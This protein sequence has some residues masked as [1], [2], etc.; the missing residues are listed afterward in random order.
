MNKPI[1]FK[2]EVPILIDAFLEDD[3]FAIDSELPK[4]MQ[5]LAQ[6]RAG[7]S[8]HKHGSF[9]D[10]LYGTYRALKLWNQEQDVC[11]CG[12]FHSVYSNEYVDLALFDPAQ[13]RS[14]LSQFLTPE[15]EQM[16]HKF[17]VMPRND[18]VVRM[19]SGEPV[20]PE[21][22]TLKDKAGS[23]VHLSSKEI[24]QY[25]VVTIADLLEQWYSWQEDTMA[26]YPFAGEVGAVP[27]WSSTLWP[28]PF[29]PGSSALSIASKLAKHLPS[30]GEPVPPIFENCT[31]VLNQ[32]DEASACA[33]FWSVSSLS[34]PQVATDTTIALLEQCIALNPH[35]GEPHLH[36]AQLFYMEGSFE[37]GV[38]HAQQG[39]R[40]I[41]A[42]G[43]PW[44]K[45]VSWSGWVIWARLL[46]QKGLERTWPSVLRD[47]NNLGLVKA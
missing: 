33:L 10:H 14:I 24:F 19:L 4:I 32:T 21:G 46:C 18:F 15:I 31:M 28:G 22:L 30:L 25:L 43:L 45:R 40:L 13:G 12:L 23:S 1:D 42:L 5:L 34:I 8:W 11:L 3:Y 9:K 41:E 27:H 35:V 37:E 16:I 6:R 39:R 26:R 38:V 2:V 17:C 36:L 7:R 44:D 47:Y 29:R 20:P